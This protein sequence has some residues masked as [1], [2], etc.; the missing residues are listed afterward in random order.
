M[1][2]IFRVEPEDPVVTEVGLE[3]VLMPAQRPCLSAVK[4]VEHPHAHYIDLD[5]IK[6]INGD[7]VEAGVQGPQ[8]QIYYPKDSPAATFYIDEIN[9]RSV[10]STAT[11]K[12]T[13]NLSK[14]YSNGKQITVISKSG[15]NIKIIN[16]LGQIILN[17]KL[18]SDTQTFTVPTNGVQFVCIDNETPVK[19]IV[20]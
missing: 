20:K 12:V 4:G 15:N 2:G 11:P 18:V 13:T 8:V 19:V 5:G 16:T 6:R 1:P 17:S 9:V 3:A 14:V 7:P 10:N